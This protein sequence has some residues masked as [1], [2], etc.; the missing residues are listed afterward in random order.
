LN[1]ESLKIKLKEDEQNFHEISFEYFGR[2]NLS[3]DYLSNI[4]ESL[5]CL[6]GINFTEKLNI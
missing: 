5:D 1:L 2:Y 3:F 4:N 6:K